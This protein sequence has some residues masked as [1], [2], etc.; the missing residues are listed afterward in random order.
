MKEPGAGDMDTRVTVRIRSDRESGDAELES[1]FTT[2]AKRWAQVTP[3][4]TAIY[5]GSK[6]TGEDMT[7]RII[8][9]RVKG[10]DARHEILCADGRLFRVQRPT[11]LNGGR[12]YTVVD[13]V[14]L[15]NGTEEDT[16]V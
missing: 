14:E 15:A 3:L 9:R 11:A 8:F 13:V 6:Q 7:H 1:E 12:V 10:L 4:G 5:T 16:H 2:V